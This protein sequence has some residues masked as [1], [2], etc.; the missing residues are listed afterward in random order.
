MT[1]DKPARGGKR[2][3]A[4]RPPSDRSS[5]TFRLRHETIDALQSLTEDRI[6]QAS[7]IDEL[8]KN[9]AE[10]KIRKTS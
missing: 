4:G 2:P 7:L 10:K 3:G 1:T 5:I 8:V 9:H 6:E